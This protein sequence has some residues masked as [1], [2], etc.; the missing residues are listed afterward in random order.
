MASQTETFKKDLDELRAAID[1][2]ASDVNTM[3]KSMSDDL[4]A[5]AKST[6]SKARESAAGMAE[7][8]MEKGKQT[9]DAVEAK[10]QAN[11]LQSLLM[12]FGLGVLLSQLIN[13]R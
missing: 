4:A 8:V 11:P 2:L 6:A 5:R 13:R 7:D 9:A 1:A 12:A 10:V 3:S